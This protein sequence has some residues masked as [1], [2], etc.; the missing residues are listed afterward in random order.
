MNWIS[1]SP[2]QDRNEHG[3]DLRVEIFD[4]RSE[5]PEVGEEYV[6]YCERGYFEIEPTRYIWGEFQGEKMYLL[7]HKGVL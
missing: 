1:N 5:F 6:I 7:L 4:D 2:I 3:K